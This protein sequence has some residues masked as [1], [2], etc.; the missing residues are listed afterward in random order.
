MFWQQRFNKFVDRMRTHD[1][2]LRLRLWTGAAFDL[3]EAPR[4]TMSILSAGGL[5]H[6]F[7]PTLDN[8]GHA[9]V[10]GEI[11]IEGSLFDVMAVAERLAA[12]GA[13]G[14]I[15]SAVR[16]V[17][18]TKEMDA[19]AITYHYDV[20]NEFYSLWLDRNMVYS[21]AYFGDGTESLEVA[22]ER[23]IDH[24]L[25]KLRLRPGDTLLDIGCGWG[26]LIIRAAEKYGV[27]ALGITL[28]QNQYD[29]AQERIARAGLADC[30]EVRIEDYRD[31]AGKFDRISSVGMFEHV[32]INHLRDYFRR[33]RDL[34][35]DD[36]IAMNHGIT[37]TDADSGDLPFGGGDFIERYVFPHGELPHIGFLLEEMS[38]A[39][40]E[41]VD[42]ESLRRHYALTLEHWAARFEAASPQLKAIAGEKTWRIWRTYLAGCAHGFA[43]NWI[44]VHQVL[45]VKAQAG[46]NIPLPLTRDYMYSKL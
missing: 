41:P 13:E 29:L 36:G 9:Y 33:I 1:I 44:S 38:A 43:H 19:E 11:D 17:L 21:C 6:F 2:P 27:K 30:C 40:L 31:V 45:T 5:K 20:S 14:S 46:R 25:T 34:L 15:R 23:K 32:G 39:G 18:H 24:I 22:Q 3:G 10:E 8:L 26:A 42:V 4:V 28:S 37:T 12:H 7:M 35:N 16:R